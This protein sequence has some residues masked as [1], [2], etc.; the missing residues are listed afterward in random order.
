MLSWKKNVRCQQGGSFGLIL[1]A[2]AFLALNVL[3]F[4][5]SADQN[6]ENAQTVSTL[7]PES[8]DDLAEIESRVEKVIVLGRQATVCVQAGG[9][10]G[11]GVIIS[12]DGFVLTA[13]HVAAEPGR[14]VTF[15]F[16]DGKKARG[17]SLGINVGIDAGLMKITDEGKWPHVELG[18]MTEMKPGSWVV[19]M[20]HPGGFDLER[21]VVARLG[22]VYRVRDTV[23]Q[24][25]CTIIGGDSGGPLFDLDGKVVGIHSR[26]SN[27]LRQNF[28]VPVSI[29]EKDWDRLA[30][31][32][33]WNR[34]PK[35][36]NLRPGGP[37][38]GVQGQNGLELG[39]GAALAR[40]YKDSPAAKAGM[41]SGDVVIE[42]DRS[43]IGSF[44]DLAEVVSNLEPGDRVPVVVLRKGERLE[45]EIVIG[46]ASE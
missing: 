36:N 18:D 45:L 32:E 44:G 3:G 9:G 2:C 19:A 41:R 33:V 43:P 30:A 40:V 21:S 17:K 31:G 35:R 39:K 25:D 37:Y 22:R 26:I 27:S 14:A 38:I 15:I 42:L 12:E 23:I 13:G 46:K 24:S 8:S 1:I 11:S 29:Y 20:G 4:S 16:P 10:S 7:V 34:L 5:A 28:H 6:D